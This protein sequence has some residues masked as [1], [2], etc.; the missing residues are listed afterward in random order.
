MSNVL[1][2]LLDLSHEIG[3]E[4]RQLAILGEGNTSAR[5]DDESFLVKAS[6]SSLPV[7]TERDLTRCRVAPLVDLLD[8]DDLDDAAVTQALLDSRVDG[9]AAKPSVESMFHA[10]LLTLPGVRFVA[11]CHPVSVNAILCSD[12]ADDFARRRLFPDEIVCCGEQSALVPYVD[13]GVPLA[14]AIREAVLA[15]ADETPR[16]I[17][18]RNH[19]IIGTGATAAGALAAVRMA[20]KAATIFLAAVSLGGPRFLADAEV[21]RIASRQ[22]E[23]HRRAALG[24]IES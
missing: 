8:R 1:D 13:P 14:R 16:V 9:R 4:S 24:L 19:G 3:V 20:E 10:Y 22:D 23:T 18:L 7:L 2:Q 5:L 6:G 12:R 17:L 15:F 11:H 21:R